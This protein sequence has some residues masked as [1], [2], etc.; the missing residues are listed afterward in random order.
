MYKYIKMVKLI[1]FSYW[2]SGFWV[3][4][5]FF[6]NFQTNAW[7]ENIYASPSFRRADPITAYQK[8]LATVYQILHIRFLFVFSLLN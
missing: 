6:F 7:D 5:P 4:V 3:L 1:D 8:E 2:I